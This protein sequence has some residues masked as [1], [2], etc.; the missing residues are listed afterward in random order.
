[1]RL[2]PY[3]WSQSI[4]TGRARLPPESTRRTYQLHWDS[5]TDGL[6]GDVLAF[7]AGS[8][9]FNSVTLGNDGGNGLQKSPHPKPLMPLLAFCLAQIQNPLELKVLVVIV[10]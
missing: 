3:V 6:R 7:G 9:S 4:K 5:A 10:L 2:R 8:F 1:M